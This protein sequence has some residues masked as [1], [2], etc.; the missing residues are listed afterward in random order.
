MTKIENYNDFFEELGIKDNT[1]REC[2]LG[3]LYQLANLILKTYGKEEKE[4]GGSI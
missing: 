3:T 4:T 2:I 1:Q